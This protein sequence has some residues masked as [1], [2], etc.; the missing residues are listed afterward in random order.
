MSRNKS[1]T[2]AAWADPDDAP[3]LS[4]RR[5]GP[6]SLRLRPSVEALRRRRSPKCRRQSAWTPISS[7]RFANKARGGKPASTP[8]YAIGSTIIERGDPLPLEEN[9]K[10]GP[11]SACDY[12]GDYRVRLHL[13]PLR[14]MVAAAIVSSAVEK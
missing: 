6:P 3:D 1:S 2:V 12:R 13:P 11:F 5:N 4:R 8:R 7:R 9:W 10:R 14:A